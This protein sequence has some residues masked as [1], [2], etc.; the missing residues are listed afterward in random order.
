[1]QPQTELTTIAA[2][3]KATAWGSTTGVVGWLLTID[4]V[5]FVGVSVAVGG[6]IVN[7]WFSYLRH[8]R[9]ER[10]S[11][12]RLTRWGDLRHDTRPATAA[13]APR[14][15][16]KPSP[17]ADITADLTHE[18]AAEKL[19]KP[20]KCLLRPTGAKPVLRR[21]SN[22]GPEDSA[23]FARPRRKWRG[24]KKGGRA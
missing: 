7:L 4:W 22:P 20:P 24:Q 14:R 9:E 2:A 18:I 8:R 16:F 21:G 6:F 12:V 15:R 13:R 19:Q 3:N 10:E 11:A 23:D 17:I 1:M 5:S